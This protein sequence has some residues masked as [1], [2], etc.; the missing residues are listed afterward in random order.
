[1][2]QG[3][4]GGATRLICIVPG[5]ASFLWP[6]RGQ[7]PC[8]LH[9]TRTP[10][11]FRYVI[12]FLGSRFLR[13]R[14]RSTRVRLIIFPLPPPVSPRSTGD[15]RASGALSIGPR[16]STSMTTGRL[17]PSP[18]LGGAHQVRGSPFDAMRHRTAGASWRDPLLT[19]DPNSQMNR[20]RPAHLTLEGTAT[21]SERRFGDVRRISPNCGGGLRVIS[22]T[23]RMRPAC[24]VCDMGIMRTAS[25]RSPTISLIASPALMV[26]GRPTSIRPCRYGAWIPAERQRNSRLRTS[27]PQ[28]NAS[29]RRADGGFLSNG[30]RRRREIVDGFLCSAGG[31]TAVVWRVAQRAGR[32]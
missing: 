11:G 10:A 32:G 9:C 15:N 27:P 29:R 24:A 22:L 12:P 16:S 23:G 2:L 6:E 8:P 17:L 5:R 19:V 31:T 13:R 18:C 3:V 21:I 14:G 26:W 28:T 4:E 25:L 7:A 30:T 20:R 1:M